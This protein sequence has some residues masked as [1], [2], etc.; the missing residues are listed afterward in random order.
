MSETADRWWVR[1]AARWL[2]R[3]DGVSGQ[4]RLAMLVMTGLSTAT[5][6]LRQYG[7]GEYAPL[8]IGVTGVGLA[9]FAYAYSE[10]GVWNQMARDRSDMSS[11][12]ATPRSKI[13]TELTGVALFAA[14]EGREPDAEERAAIEA[15]VDEQWRERRDGVELDGGRDD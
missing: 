14:L 7:L 6:S 15:A 2:A 11:N 9:V 3:V 4:I 1:V 10:G 8:F 5:L 13:N 12:H